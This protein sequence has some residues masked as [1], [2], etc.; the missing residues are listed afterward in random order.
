MKDKLVIF[1]VYDK[2][3]TL[4]TNDYTIL[5]ILLLPKDIYCL[6]VLSTLVIPD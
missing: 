3:F 1:G 5:G 4:N 2:G 6:I